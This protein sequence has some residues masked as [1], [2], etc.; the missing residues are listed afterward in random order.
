MLVAI[1]QARC[2]TARGREEKKR[3]PIN[4][5][6]FRFHKPAFS[7]YLLGHMKLSLEQ[8]E[9]ALTSLEKALSQE[10]N[11]FT[12][13]ASIQRFE[14]TLELAWKTAG[15]LLQKEGI[16][17]GLSPKNVIRECYQM[18]WIA[19]PEIWMDFLEK[20]NLTSHAYN[21]ATANEVYEVAKQMAPLA[22]ELLQK[23]VGASAK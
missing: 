12:R 20:R 6:L 22:R 5:L 4:V 1:S 2:G 15:K 8:F 7:G 9:K 3:I 10:K 23:L 16:T 11:E 14:F 19:Q 18:G 21:E 17:F 13:D